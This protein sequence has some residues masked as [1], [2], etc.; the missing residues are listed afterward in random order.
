MEAA[1]RCVLPTLLPEG[2]TFA[3]YTSQ[4]KRALM[5]DLPIR[6][7]GY[8]SYL[9]PNWRIVVVVDRDEEDCRE[10]KSQLEGFSRQAGLVTKTM[11][12]TGAW[13]VANRL[14]IEELEAWFFG[15]MDAV[16]AAYP[17]VSA[18]VERG[19]AYRDPDAIGGGTCEALER[20]LQHAGYF[21]GGLRKIE[22]ARAIAAHLDPSRNRSRSFQVFRDAILALAL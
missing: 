13:Q 19:A 22:A 17:R 6:L 1:L 8:R 11:A 3:I 9:R 18:T 15:D 21:K 20:V 7:A 10:L 12:G 4:G 14:A 2:I 5:R 16:R